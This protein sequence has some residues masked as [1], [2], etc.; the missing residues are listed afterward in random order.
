MATMKLLIVIVIVIV[1]D[2]P[3]VDHDCDHDGKRARIASV[4]LREEHGSYGHQSKPEHQ[5]LSAEDTHPWMLS[6]TMTTA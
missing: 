4:E 6:I 1:I 3:R 2:N 5:A